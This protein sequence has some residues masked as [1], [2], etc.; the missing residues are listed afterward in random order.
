MYY[1]CVVLLS[2]FLSSHDNTLQFSHGQDWAFSDALA[3]VSGSEKGIGDKKYRII[4]K[5]ANDL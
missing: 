5:A 3:M 2:V 1:F 4:H